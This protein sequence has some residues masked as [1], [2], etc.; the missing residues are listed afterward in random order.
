VNGPEIQWSVIKLNH[1]PIGPEIEW[2][3]Q[4]SGPLF[5][6]WTG[7]QVSKMDHLTQGQQLAIQYLVG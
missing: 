2:S 7:N 5:D 4:N 1:G 6:F 3:I